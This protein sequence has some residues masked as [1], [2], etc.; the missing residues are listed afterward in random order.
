MTITLP[1]GNRWLIDPFETIEVTSEKHDLKELF[2]VP[3]NEQRV[4]NALI[5]EIVSKCHTF[6]DDSWIGGTIDLKLRD[7]HATLHYVVIAWQ[8]FG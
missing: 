5:G 1:D 6:D 2:T 3:G 4:R 7:Q 8:L